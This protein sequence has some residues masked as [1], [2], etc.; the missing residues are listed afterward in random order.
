MRDGLA[1]AT[2]NSV[3]RPPPLQVGL[4]ASPCVAHRGLAN[5]QDK[6]TR[7]IRGYR[8]SG[9]AQRSA[10][11][12]LAGPPDT[13]VFFIA[14]EWVQGRDVYSEAH[15]V[16]GKKVEGYFKMRKEVR[17]CKR[18]SCTAQWITAQLR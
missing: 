4:C 6:M 2:G 16:H 7:G 1:H 18:L 3:P 5:P 8:R 11:G 12:Q 13:V 10:R 14:V 15:K 9:E 17:A